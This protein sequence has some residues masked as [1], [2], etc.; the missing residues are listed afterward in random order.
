MAT[1]ATRS[2]NLDLHW[3]VLDRGGVLCGLV[4]IHFVE[5]PEFRF[6]GHVLGQASLDLG[7]WGRIA[8]FD[9]PLIEN[10]AS[11]AVALDI[12]YVLPGG[13]SGKLMR[14]EATA[15]EVHNSRSFGSL[16]CSSFSGGDSV[17]TRET[18]STVRILENGDVESGSHPVA[19]CGC[20]EEEG[21]DV[22]ASECRSVSCRVTT[23]ARVPVTLCKGESRGPLRGKVG[24]W[25]AIDF[26]DKE[27]KHCGVI[28]HS[29]MKGTSVTKPA[30]TT[31]ATHA[32]KW[33]RTQANTRLEKKR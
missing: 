13:D 8:G 30:P 21:Q 6:Q 26:H 9:L 17:P 16:P 14:S 18:R 1:L 25:G 12:R 31:K 7:R 23:R 20:P 24:H 22:A 5:C 10:V 32:S 3:N 28:D 19:S 33:T 4:P 15:S 27:G 2:R 29:A 11:Q